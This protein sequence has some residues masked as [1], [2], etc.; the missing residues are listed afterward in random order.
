MRWFGKVG[1]GI[2]TK[3]GT[4]V[5]TEEIVERDYY[6]DMD[7]RINHVQ[8]G[9]GINDNMQLNMQVRIVADAFAYEHFQAIR[10]VVIENSKWKVSSVEVNRPRLTLNFGSVYTEE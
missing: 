9:E 8:T 6:G 1:Y 2:T 10:Y 5:Y 7:R 3:T 4:D